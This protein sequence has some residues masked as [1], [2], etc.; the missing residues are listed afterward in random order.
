MEGQSYDCPED[1]HQ[2]LVVTWGFDKVCER[3]CYATGGRSVFSC[4]GAANLLCRNGS[5]AGWSSNGH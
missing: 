4:Q 3:C 1:S 5:S 2:N